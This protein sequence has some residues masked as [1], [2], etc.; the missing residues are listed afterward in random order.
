VGRENQRTVI[1]R[2]TRLSFASDAVAQIAF[3]TYKHKQS[4][5]ITLF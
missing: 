2:V 3:A 1:R 5:N 4:E